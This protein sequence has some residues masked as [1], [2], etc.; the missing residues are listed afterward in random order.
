MKAKK[1]GAVVSEYAEKFTNPKDL[2]DE[3]RAEI[4][5]QEFVEFQKDMK[6]KLGMQ[7]G[8]RLQK[9]ENETSFGYQAIMVPV[10][11]MSEKPVAPAPK[12][13]EDKETKDN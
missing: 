7:I 3:K 5:S 6:N 10:K 11:L 2:S 13:N 1:K 9:V 4:L 8:V 12:S